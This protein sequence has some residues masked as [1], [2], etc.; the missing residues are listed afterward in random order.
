MANAHPVA[1]AHAYPSTDIYTVAHIY[2][3]ADT[4]IYPLPDI[5]TVADS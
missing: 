2:P 5:H 4:D 3:V 1:D